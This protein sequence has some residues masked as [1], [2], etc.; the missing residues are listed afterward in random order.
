MIDAVVGV[1]VMVTATASLMAALEVTQ[2]AIRAAGRYPLTSDE[3][4]ILRRLGK[5]NVEQQDFWSLNL[6]TAPQEIGEKSR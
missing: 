2:Q 5:G 6:A 1:V 4:E 3:K